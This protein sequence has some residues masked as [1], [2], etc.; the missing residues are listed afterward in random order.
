MFPGAKDG[1]LRHEGLFISASSGTDGPLKCGG[2]E[3][4]RINSYSAKN[5]S[6]KSPA[7]VEQ[8]REKEFCYHQN[9]HKQLLRC[10]SETE[11]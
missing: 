9:P 6:C 8:T 1:P 11:Q 4:G 3:S 2:H 10:S 7:L 5:I